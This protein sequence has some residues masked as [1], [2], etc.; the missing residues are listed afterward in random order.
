[1]FFHNLS[2]GC[3]FSSLI[4]YLIDLSAQTFPREYSRNCLSTSDNFIYMIDVSTG[5]IFKSP[6]FTSAKNREDR[7]VY[8]GWKTFVK[9]KKLKF[10][11]KVVF[12]AKN[13][14]HVIEVQI[15]RRRSS[16]R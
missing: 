14:N 1:M 6:I 16:N 3:L 12:D 5:R 10:K 7:Y 11:D 9:E 2:H 15:H 8:A 13:G 4:S